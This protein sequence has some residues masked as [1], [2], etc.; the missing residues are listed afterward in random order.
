MCLPMTAA[1]LT[2]PVRS[3]QKGHVPD[4]RHATSAG[5]EPGTNGCANRST[6]PGLFK[7]DIAT[8][9]RNNG[10]IEAAFRLLL[11]AQVGERDAIDVRLTI[12]G[13]HECDRPPRPKALPSRRGAISRSAN[14]EGA[15][16]QN[17]SFSAS[18]TLNGSPGPMPG[19]PRESPIVSPMRPSPPPTRLP[20]CARLTRLKM[21]NISRRS[22]ARTWFCNGMFLNTE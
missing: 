11:H 19:D 6:G 5:W 8:V 4:G 16:I 20:G 21:L 7:A 22:C 17:R 1:M 3:A 9:S 10:A 2:V 12:E 15:G 13:G 18:C 14:A